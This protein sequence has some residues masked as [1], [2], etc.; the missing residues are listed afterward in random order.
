MNERVELKKT[1]K[2][3]WVWAIALGSAI[4]WGCFVLPTEWM[5]KSG[6]LGAILGLAIGGLLMMVIAVSYGELIK[7]YPVS[8]GGF[9]YAYLGFGRV[10]A[11][12]CGWFL[13]LAYV[14]I[15]ALN[16]SAMALLGKFVIPSVANL[17]F[18]YEVSGWEVYLGEVI[19]ASVSLIIFAFLNIK[20]TS[21]SGQMQF[22]FC[23]ILVLGVI[24][25]T[26][27]MLLHPDTS[28]SNAKPLFNP[29]ISVFS[30][31]LIILAM[32]PWAYVGF[33]NIPQAAEEFNFPPKKAF[34]LIIS[35]LAFAIVLYS[36]MIIASA[37]SVPWQQLVAGKPVWGTADV[38][39]STLGIIGSIFLVL[40]VLMGILTGANGFYVSSSRLM[41][42]MGRA[43][44][45]PSAFAKLH[46][47]YGTPHI[48]IIAT[49]LICLIAPWFG[50]QVLLWIVDMSS[51]GV[52][53]AYLYTC[54]SAYK[55]FRWK[56]EDIGSEKTVAPFKKAISLVGI[57]SSIAFLCLL[58][59]PGSPSFMGVPSMIA[60]A[61]WTGLGIIFF[62]VK[63]KTYMKLDKETLDFYILGK[64]GAE[65][66][67]AE[68][69]LAAD[70]AFITVDK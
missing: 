37:V 51:V 5:G 40:S 61:I 56:Q 7:K 31:I 21:F 65:E 9:T 50:R 66:E 30:S 69:G 15:V 54:C 6:P 38:V 33:D 48:G 70:P 32:A 16:A 24:L 58:L 41:F 59:I 47:K 1:F 28:L 49:C 55:L 2:Q 44:I 12:I 45:L 46:P 68:E 63:Q 25:L 27:S 3:H 52:T 62:I 18:M 36:F 23:V 26:A 42:A 35:S 13:T 53:I 43:N 39:S 11:F 17:F 14:C 20:G 19:I 29:N 64:K 10:H 8:G 34:G 22:I 57:I 60:L 4:G 67:S